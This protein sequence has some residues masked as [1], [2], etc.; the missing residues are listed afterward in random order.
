[1]SA[2]H[3]ILRKLIDHSTLGGFDKSRLHFVNDTD[4]PDTDSPAPADEP[5]VAETPEQELARLR[6]ENA[7]L[8]VSRETGGDTNPGE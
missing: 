2:I 3:D 5:T 4:D 8:K 7:S 6:T 1:M